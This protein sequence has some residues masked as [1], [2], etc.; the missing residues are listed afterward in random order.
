MTE[1]IIELKNISK[2][3]GGTAALDDVSID[4]YPGEVHSF[5][6]VNGAGKSTLMKIMLGVFPCDSGQMLIN[7]SEVRF[8]NPGEAIAHGV[9][10]VYQELN[11]FPRMTIYENL[12]MGRFIKTPLGM[13]DREAGIAKCQ[14]FLSSVGIPLD[15]RTHVDELSLARQQLV[16]I[17]KCVF[18]NPRILILDEPSSSLSYGEQEILHSIVR[19]LK[20]RGLS[21][22]YITHKM[23]ELEQLSDRI[24]ILRD[25]KKISEG[26]AGEYSLSRITREMLGKGIDFDINTGGFDYKNAVEVL[27][28]EHLDCGA[29]VKDISFTLHKGEILALT[30]LIGCGKSET[31]RTIFGINGRVSGTVKVRGKPYAITRPADAIA[32]SMGYMPISRKEEGIFVNFD[33]TQNISVAVLDRFGLFINRKKEAEIAE[34]CRNDFNIRTASMSAMIGSLSGGNQQKTILARWVSRCGDILILDE[35]TRGIDV[36]AK[37]EIYIK[38][39]K[40]AGEGAGIL[41]ISSELDEI[42]GVAHRILVMRNGK[43]TA[44]LSP[45]STTEVEV[46]QLMMA[47]D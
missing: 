8:R 10:M 1:P 35:P 27:K 38:L 3:F 7:G 34:H 42:L 47:R 33:V 32:R 14:E 40:L 24:T 21:I 9:S 44:E 43:I 2:S 19:N 28:V 18:Q 36:G 13:V 5:V 41:L 30:G 46:M 20:A 23:E 26:M 16:E 15:A 37:Q 31:A 6:G 11:L 25:G 17:A 45:R 4:I 39:R 12:M 29:V 22:L